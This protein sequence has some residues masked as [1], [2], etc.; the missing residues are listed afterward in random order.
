MTNST[1]RPGMLYGIECWPTK[2]QHA[3]QLSIAEMRMLQWICDHTRRYRVW[4]DNIR[5]RLG[6]AP[7]EEKLVQ[8]HLR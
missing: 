5:E 2:R 7:I 3:Q 6:M 1:I 8:H 4:N